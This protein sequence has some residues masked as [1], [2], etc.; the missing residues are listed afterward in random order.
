MDTPGS[1]A[2][3]TLNSVFRQNQIGDFETPTN[4]FTPCKYRMGWPLI[5]ANQ[6]INVRLSRQIPAERNYIIPF[7]RD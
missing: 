7:V 3:A 6:D 5:V 1:Y 2:F 4:G